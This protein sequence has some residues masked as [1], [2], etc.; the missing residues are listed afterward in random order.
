MKLL[1]LLGASLKHSFSP[2]L[3][4]GLARSRNFPF[5][6]FP[7]EIREKDLPRFVQAVRLLPI[8]GFNVTI[9]HKSA[10][11]H[12]LDETTSKVQAIGAANTVLNGGGKLIGYNTDT[13]GFLS[14]VKTLFGEKV[15]PHKVLILG[16]G[17]AA[18]AVLY[19]LLSAGTKTAFVANRNAARAEKL[20]EEFSAA[21]PDAQ[22]RPGELGE[23]FL[24]LTVPAVELIVQSTSVG[25][26]PRVED[27][28]PFPFE[29]LQAG[30]KVIDLVYNPEETRFLREVRRRGLEAL[31]GLPMLIGQAAE[32]LA[33]WGFAGQKETLW[34]IFKDARETRERSEK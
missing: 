21:F 2:A 20:A 29:K 31:N 17:G 33:I 25:M 9:P 6:Y 12:F 22:I 8:A 11:L 3:M 7:F 18:R 24:A 14:S 23:D 13:A 4:N 26:W 1:G 32:S 15:F 34:E 19:A 5:A 30:Q 28:V 16:S 27:V 10:I